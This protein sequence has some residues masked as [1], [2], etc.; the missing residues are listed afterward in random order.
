MLQY[1]E[2]YSLWEVEVLKVIALGSLSF[3]IHGE[4]LFC[5][6]GGHYGT[7]EISFQYLLDN[8]EACYLVYPCHSCL[9]YFKLV[10]RLFYVG[11]LS[12]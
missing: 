3:P 12:I 9:G 2:S 11:Y 7:Q 10:Q 4:F 5:L 8:M 1:L 6:P